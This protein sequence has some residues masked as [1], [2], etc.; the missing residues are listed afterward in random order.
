MSYSL[1]QSLPLYYL[2]YTCTL[3]E[4][5]HHSPIFSVISLVKSLQFLYPLIIQFL[6][7]SLTFVTLQK[8][9]HKIRLFLT[10]HVLGNLLANLFITIHFA[11]Q[12]SRPAQFFPNLGTGLTLYTFLIIL[13]ITGFLQRFALINKYRKTWKFLH[14]SSIMTLF[15]IIVIHLLHGIGFL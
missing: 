6:G 9:P 14:T 1:L 13:V 11:S 7:S 8:Y 4:N 12:I 15:I 5:N 3:K 2:D 10:I